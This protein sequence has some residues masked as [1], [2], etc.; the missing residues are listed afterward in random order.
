MGLGEDAVCSCVGQDSGEVRGASGL[1]HR[2][3]SGLQ[4]S[5]HSPVW[6]RLCPEAPVFILSREMCYTKTMGVEFL[7]I[8]PFLNLLLMWLITKYANVKI[9]LNFWSKHNLV[10]MSFLLQIHCYI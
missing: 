10:M 9:T 8:R 7:V 2:G 1:P 3:V 5:F 6:S 4:V